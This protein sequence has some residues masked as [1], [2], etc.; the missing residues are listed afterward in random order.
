MICQ[1]CGML[2]GEGIVYHPYLFCE[3]FKLGYDDP[4]AYLRS[5]GFERVHPGAEP[6]AQW[7]LRS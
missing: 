6:E 7:D 5:Y 3:L 1:E 2:V 4:F